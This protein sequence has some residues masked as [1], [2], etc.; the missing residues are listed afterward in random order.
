LT[1]GRIDH[2]EFRKKVASISSIEND[3]IDNYYISK[4]MENEELIKRVNEQ[5]LQL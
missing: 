5:L 3:D 2:D 1:A 4:P